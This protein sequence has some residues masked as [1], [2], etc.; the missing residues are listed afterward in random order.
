MEKEM[1]LKL[2]KALQEIERLRQEN[3]QL[4]KKL[5]IDVSE[6]KAD[7]SQSGPTSLG[8][9]TPGLKKLRK[10]G[11]MEVHGLSISAR[12]PRVSS[13]LSAQEEAKVVSDALQGKRGCR[14]QFFGSMSEL[15]GKAMRQLA[16]IHGVR[17]KE[18]QKIIF[19]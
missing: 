14:M 3:A 16:R 5:G 13:N 11:A 7:Y 17:R 6:P 2:E 18:R 15:E 19:L 4:R 9:A 1:T 12:P 8:A 10:P